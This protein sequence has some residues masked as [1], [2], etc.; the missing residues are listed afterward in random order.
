MAPADGRRIQT[1]TTTRKKAKT[2]MESTDQFKEADIM[3]IRFLEFLH[4]LDP[5]DSV[6]L[7]SQKVF[8]VSSLA[9]GSTD[10]VIYAKSSAFQKKCG[11]HIGTS[12]F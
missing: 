4:F 12:K 7:H 3:S 10:L 1:R 8:P 11:F 5:V 6:S 9:S 2:E